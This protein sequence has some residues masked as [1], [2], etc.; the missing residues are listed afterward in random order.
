[1]TFHLY[2]FLPTPQE[3]GAAQLLAINSALTRAHA[4]SFSDIFDFS[5]FAGEDWEV[6]QNSGEYDDFNFLFSWKSDDGAVLTQVQ[7]ATFTVDESE[8]DD[9][10]GYDEND[11]THVGLATFSTKNGDKFSITRKDT[12]RHYADPDS[13]SPDLV[14]HTFN[15]SNQVNAKYVGFTGVA[16]DVTYICQSNTTGWANDDL[17][18]GS[19]Y[20]TWNIAGK[21]SAFSIKSNG[22]YTKKWGFFHE[23]ELGSA[24]ISH[25]NKFTSY[26][27]TDTDNGLSLSF[28]GSITYRDLDEG[29]NCDINLKKVIATTADYK[30][31]T[32]VL[33]VRNQ[34]NFHFDAMPKDNYSQVTVN[35][36]DELEPIMMRAANII[37]ITNRDGAYIDADNG[38]DKI[39][40]NTGSDVIKGGAGK[41]IINGG[42]TFSAANVPIQT[43]GA[44]LFVYG[45]ETAGYIKSISVDSNNII[46][47]PALRDLN[48]DTIADFKPGEDQIGIDAREIGWSEAYRGVDAIT[49]IMPS[50]FKIF[51]AGTTFP[52]TGTGANG[53]SSTAPLNQGVTTGPFNNSYL[54]LVLGAT[55]STLYIDLDAGGIVFSPVALATLTGVTTT[56]YLT[57]PMT[58]T[59]F[60]LLG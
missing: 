41:D 16:D 2:P 38:A 25:V 30:C 42:T 36:F 17:S 40:G 12:V 58:N 21:T 23:E 19:R 39:T 5:E 33:N 54:M 44:D 15:H 53:I 56:S 24:S 37:T 22:T 50:Q 27:Y 11:Y 31:T 6:A 10:P 59:D 49:E 8:G 29:N 4:P 45:R 9:L 35:Y 26:A 34:D 52:T 18:T 55:S 20:D 43:G 32:A 57:A 60:L 1:M 14:W 48:R 13:E 28:N 47:S 46:I 7:S 3:D 51:A